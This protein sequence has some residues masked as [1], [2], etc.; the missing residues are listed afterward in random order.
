MP[1]SA[2]TGE[3]DQPWTDIHSQ[4]PSCTRNKLVVLLLEELVKGL[5]LF[6][7]QGFAPFRGDWGQL[8]ALKGRLIEV[9]TAKGMLAG[10]A[11]GIN[12]SGALLLETANETLTLYSGEV[13]LGKTKI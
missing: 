9:E 1:A 4:L 5:D 3:I 12:E 6:A 10:R 2:L 8:D 11:A 7:R 13:S